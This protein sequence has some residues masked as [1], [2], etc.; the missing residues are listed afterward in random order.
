MATFALVRQEDSISPGF[1][2]TQSVLRA[3]AICH[4]SPLCCNGFRPLDLVQNVQRSACLFRRLSIRIC[5]APPGERSQVPPPPLFHS[6]NISLNGDAIPTAAPSPT[7]GH[8]FLL[9]SA[10]NSCLHAHLRPLLDTLFSYKSPYP[11]VDV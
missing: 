8:H 6:S 10:I 7:P 11:P 4:I 5:T 2:H 9:L 1:V 3:F